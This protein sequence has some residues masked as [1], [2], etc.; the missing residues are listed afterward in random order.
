MGAIE[1]VVDVVTDN[2]TYYNCPKCN[3]EVWAYGSYVGNVCL[4]CPGTLSHG[5]VKTVDNVTFGL[6]STAID[7]MVDNKTEY[8]CPRCGVKKWA[9]GVGIGRACLDCRFKD[10]NLYDIGIYEDWFNMSEASDLEMR[11]DDFLDCYK[12][13]TVTLNGHTFYNVTPKKKVRKS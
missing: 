8:R 1:T 2:R 4:D 3:R 7:A 11:F 5:V 13:D 10:E 6:T 12:S 9:Y